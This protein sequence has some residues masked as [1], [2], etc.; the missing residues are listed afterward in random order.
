MLTVHR[1]AAVEMQQV[2]RKENNCT[3]ICCN[4]IQLL[5]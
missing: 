2:G 1:L 5:T 4:I 3:F